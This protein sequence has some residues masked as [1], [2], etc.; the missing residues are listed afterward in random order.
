VSSLVLLS[1]LQLGSGWIGD[2][3]GRPFADGMGQVYMDMNRTVRV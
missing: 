2:Q 1:W 3:A